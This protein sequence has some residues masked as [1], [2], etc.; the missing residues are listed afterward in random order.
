MFSLN[1]RSYI[2]I[3]IAGTFLLLMF[4]SIPASSAHILIV[5]DPNS[6][7]PVYNEDAHYAAQ[8]LKD[9]GYQVR[10][11]YGKEATSKNVLKGMYNADGIIYVSKGYGFYNKTTGLAHGPYA[12]PTAD[13]KIY[14][15]GT[16]MQEGK[17]GPIFTPPFKKTGILIIL[18]HQC[19]ACGAANSNRQIVHINNAAE[20]V[21]N[22]SLMFTGN[23][24]NFLGT[25][26]YLEDWMEEIIGY[27]AIG[28]A[29]AL[30]Y[31]DMINGVKIWDNDDT[32]LAIPGSPPNNWPDVDNGNGKLAPAPTTPYDDA[33]AE[34]WYNSLH[35]PQDI[36]PPKVV[37]T[38]PPNNAKDVPADQMIKITF[39]EPIKA[40]AH[41]SDIKLKS[42]S[43][44]SLT[45]NKII[46]GK[47]LTIKLASGYFKKGVK[48][49]LNLPV[50]SIQDNVVNGLI[51]TYKL[52]FTVNY[53]IKKLVNNNIR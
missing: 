46:S 14:A 3:L 1:I 6:D 41:Y 27:G 52:I 31:D 15:A 49:T 38:T 24:A 29:S 34:K 8:Y 33:A 21:Y 51:T 7:R 13:G 20:T 36:T 47:V 53:N 4:V 22:Y 30:T 43:G 39:S 32:A 48:Y 42:S 19:L 40:G 18:A 11:L 35:G 10:E 23:N 37:S 17:D 25:A 16:K 28:Y 45:I 44:T 12:L 5:G 50:K 2:P 9:N 26:S